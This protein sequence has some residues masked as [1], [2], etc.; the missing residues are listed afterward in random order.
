MLQAVAL[1]AVRPASSPA[2]DAG[3][4]T[5]TAATNIEIVPHVKCTPPPVPAVATKRKCPSSH[6]MT[7][8]YIAA[9]VSNHSAPPVAARIRTA[10]AAILVDE[11]DAVGA[12]TAIP[13]GKLL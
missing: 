12:M 1:I 11:E 5:A 10:I 8:P 4:P 6:A 2:V 9:T 3:V 13:A 7:G